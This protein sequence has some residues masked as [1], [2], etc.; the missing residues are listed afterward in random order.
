[1]TPESLADLF[2]SD[3]EDTDADDPLWTDVEIFGYMDQSAKQFARTTDYFADASTTEIVDVAVTATEKFVSLDPRI[4][5]IRGARLAGSGIEITPKTY[6]NVNQSGYGRD[7]YDNYAFSSPINWENSIGNPTIII[8]DLEKDK[9]RLVPIP[10][11]DDIINLFVYRLP[12]LDITE[13]SATFEITEVEY[14]RG[15]MYYMK[16]LAYQKNDSDVYNEQLSEAS[17]VL[18]DS[19]MDR[20][21]SAL[22]RQRFSSTIGTV[23]YGGL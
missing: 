11:S 20:A 21:K 3:I 16:Y 5:K 13:D 2:R 18:A 19:F 15:L 23:R 1:M 7:A 17:F 12:L 10:V 4:T 14:Q 6:A 9:G 22:R 8:T